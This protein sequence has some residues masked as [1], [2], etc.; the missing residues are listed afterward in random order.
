MFRRHSRRSRSRS[1][2]RRSEWGAAQYAATNL[3]DVPAG[4]VFFDADWIKVPSGAVNNSTTGLDKE[5][6]D[7]TL[8]RLLPSFGMNVVIGSAGFQNFGF[9][10]GIMVWEQTNDASPPVVGPSAV[11]FPTANG[12]A[13]WIWTDYGWVAG[14]FTGATSQFA[15]PNSSDILNQSRAMRKLSANQ[16]LIYVIGVD[17]S[18]GDSGLFNFS[19][20]IFARAHFKLP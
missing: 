11:P 16:G 9:A 20:Q 12:D 17:N 6:E 1:S 18:L 19:Y 3:S 14:S 15:Q 2:R 7:W 10:V 4:T 13:D 8:T 5:D